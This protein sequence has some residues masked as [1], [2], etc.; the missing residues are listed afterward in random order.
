[1]AYCYSVEHHGVWIWGQ[2]TKLFSQLAEL[3]RIETHLSEEY[4]SG[5]LPKSKK[6]I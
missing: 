1:M 2:S 5:T 4:V 6:N 3:K